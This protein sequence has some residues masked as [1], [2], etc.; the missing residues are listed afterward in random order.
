MACR[1][2]FLVSAAVLAAAVAGCGGTSKASSSSS[3]TT[4]AASPATVVRGGR[5][6][7]VMSDFRFRPNS[8]AT[9]PGKLAVTA[10]NAGRDPHELVL[11]RTDKA[12]NKL[13]VKNAKAS[14]AGS[15]GE[16]REQPPGKS[17]S[18]TFN[19]KAGKYVYI[20]NIPGHYQ[21]GMSGALT[22]K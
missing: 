3:G 8:L 13:P 11:I 14:E 19:L 17:A 2:W 15:V 4:A 16:V 6:T 10:K 20:C 9:R 18:H 5:V 21:L 7:V 1:S 22:V 12:P